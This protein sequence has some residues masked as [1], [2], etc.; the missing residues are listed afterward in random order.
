M[1]N[2]FRAAGAALGNLARRGTGA[3]RGA[4]AGRRSRRAASPSAARESGS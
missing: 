4:G 3:A 2:R 1:R